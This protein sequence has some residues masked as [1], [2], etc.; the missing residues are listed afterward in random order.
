MP[1]GA[2]LPR[3]WGLGYLGPL[4]RLQCLMRR[5]GAT[6]HPEMCPPPLPWACSPEPHLPHPGL[7]R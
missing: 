1:G 5:R 4:G 7:Q 6:P 3:P 2:W